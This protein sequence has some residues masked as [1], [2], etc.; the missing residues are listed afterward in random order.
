MQFQADGVP[1]GGPVNDLINWLI[2]KN[3][4]SSYLH[5]FFCTFPQVTTAP[6][7]WNLAMQKFNVAISPSSAEKG[8]VGGGEGLEDKV[9]SNLL[10]KVLSFM[11]AWIETDFHRDFLTQDATLFDPLVKDF[12]A[13]LPSKKGNKFKL[14]MIRCASKK[15]RTGR[16]LKLR[17]SSSEDVNDPVAAVTPP[18]S[19]SAR[20]PVGMESGGSL[21]TQGPRVTMGGTPVKDTPKRSAPLEAGKFEFPDLT[22]EEVADQLTL[23][24]EKMF[25]RIKDLEFL[26][27]NGKTDDE[28]GRKKGSANILK[29]VERFNS[30]SYWV[31][32][33]IVMQTELR[34][35]VATLKKFV[36]IAEHL[37]SIGNF[38]GVMEIIGGLNL[39]AVSRLKATWEQI[40]PGQKKKIEE[41]NALME[42]IQNYKNYRAA[43]KA[44]KLPL[45]PYLGVYLRDITFIDEGNTNYL[46]EAKMVVNF[47]KLCLIGEILH[48]IKRYQS[49]AFDILPDTVLQEFL[50]KVQ[51][52]PEEMLYKHSLLC[53]GNSGTDSPKG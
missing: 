17:S 10:H 41:L 32:T 19:P 20:K 40:P 38:N 15:L 9:S 13:R 37:E 12:I 42:S 33:E 46:D 49:E 6:Q 26:N 53:E 23:I 27:W 48:Q 39:F 34:K 18:P 7:V 4:D 43:V 28:N 2:E 51:I 5:H 11:W 36:L 24:E 45:L 30:V 22:G 1:K 47:E 29:M 21:R 31:A 3:Q 35:R 44:A 14:L 16:K 8:E 50:H 25:R 52:L